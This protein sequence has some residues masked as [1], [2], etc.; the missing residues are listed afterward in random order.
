MGMKLIPTKIGL[1]YGNCVPR[2]Q[3]CPKEML[4]GSQGISCPDMSGMSLV[5]GS[6]TF[7]PC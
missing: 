5:M 1:V 6:N 7:S 2:D 4:Q 3:D